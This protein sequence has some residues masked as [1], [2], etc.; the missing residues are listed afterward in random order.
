MRRNRLV[1]L[2]RNGLA[3]PEKRLLAGLTDRVCVGTHDSPVKMFANTYPIGM[4]RGGDAYYAMDVTDPLSPSLKWQID[5]STTGFSNL[6]QSWSKASLVTVNN[7]GTHERML[8]F[9]GGY[10]AAKNLLLRAP[11]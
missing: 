1:R 8:E 3:G 9:S 7:A 4:R 6:A 11:I 10:N 5:A 2:D